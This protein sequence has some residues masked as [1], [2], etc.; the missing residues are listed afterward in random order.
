M[1]CFIE[2]LNMVV[3]QATTAVFI[4]CFFQETQKASWVSLVTKGWHGRRCTPLGVTWMKVWNEEQL[5]QYPD[6]LEVRSRSGRQATEHLAPPCHGPSLA[7]TDAVDTSLSHKLFLLYQV[8]R[9]VTCSPV[10]CA[11][12]LIVTL[13]S[14]P[15]FMGDQITL[16]IRRFYRNSWF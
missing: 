16:Q 10:S 8:V 9:V 5:L 2:V 4:A 6:R 3:K 7:A 12:L 14:V 15:W 1:R 11:A 13:G